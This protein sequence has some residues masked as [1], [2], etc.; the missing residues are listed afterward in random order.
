MP[1]FELSVT[2][3]GKGRPVT[4]TLP[5]QTDEGAAK[6]YVRTFYQAM[7]DFVANAETLGHHKDAINVRIVGDNLADGKAKAKATIEVHNLSQADYQAIL[8]K[9]ASFQGST[10][11]A[12]AEA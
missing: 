10:P 3:H 5:P 12:T 1:K 6:A 4:V 2:V 8:D 9:L 11:P 7:S